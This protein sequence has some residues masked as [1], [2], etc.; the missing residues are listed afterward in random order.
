[1]LANLRNTEK[2]QKTQNLKSNIDRT[3]LDFWEKKKR[4]K[5]SKSTAH[6]RTDVNAAAAH[7][8]FLN[9]LKTKRLSAL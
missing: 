6:C 5:I 7:T 3:N 9:S 4:K 2:T 1:M 8:R